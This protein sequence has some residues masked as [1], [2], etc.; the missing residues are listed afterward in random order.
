MSES[1][2]PIISNYLLFKELGTDC[3]GVNYRAGEIDQ[4][5]RKAA[6]HYHFT[7]VF[8]FLA[9]NTN[10]WK[11]INI[12]LE[13]VK[14]S[15]IPKLYSPEH[16]VHE[17][18]KTF[19]VYQV[20]NGKT[21]EHVL[22]DSFKKDNPINFDLAFSIA[23]AIGDLI[24]VGSSIVVSGEK[25][26]HGFLTPDNILIDYDGKIFLKNYGI[27]PYISR[28]EEIFNEMVKKY[29]AWIAP[30]FLRKEKLVCQTDIYHLGYIIYKIL[31]GKYFSC[32]PEEDFD[33]KFSNISF[34]QHIPSSDKDFLTDIITFFKKTLHPQPSQRFANIKEFKDFISNKFHIEELSSVT[35]NLA[36][37]MN[38]IYLESMEAENKELEN[39]LAYRIPEPEPEPQPEPASSKSSDH[40]VSDILEGLDEHEKKSSASK[41]IFPLI[42]VIVIIIALGTYFFISQQKQAKQQAEQQRKIQADFVRLKQETEREKKERD[43]RYEK[44]LKEIQDQTA[45]TEEERKAQEEQIR[46]LKE[47]QKEEARKALAKQKEAEDRIAKQKQAEED[48]KQEEAEAETK[49]LEDEK[50]KEAERIKQEQQDAEKKRLEEE[51]K[52]IKPGQLIALTAATKKPVKLKGKNPVFSSLLRRK[53]RGQKFTVR[54]I[55]LVDENGVVVSVKMQGKPPKDL[56]EVFEKVF[57]KWKYTPAE[58]DGIKVKV[59]IVVGMSVSF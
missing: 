33:S 45:N 16:I 20:M 8:P 50:L 6:K 40:L 21:F 10:V 26:F 11:R 42:A 52:R 3:I 55:V 58:K 7:E 37:F 47:R 14:K 1:E 32:T 5:E 30:E 35:F 23:F 17:D 53:Y 24:D 44:Q 34:S 57:A 9:D 54:S 12:L 29:G 28:E 15:N 4:D 19:L 27:Y 39:E 41:L 2:Y 18:D 49:R 56:K 13:G 22:E 59:W 51:A 46:Q 36:Y 48:K 31:T 43:Q 25:S 38:S